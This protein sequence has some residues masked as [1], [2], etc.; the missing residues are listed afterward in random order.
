MV[1]KQWFDYERSTFKYI[2]EVKE[3]GSV[4]FKYSNDFDTNGILYWIGTNARTSKEWKNPNSIKSVVVSSS[5]G[6]NLPYG[7]LD[8]VLSRGKAAKNVHT[9]DDRNGWL[10]I[11][12]ALWIIPTHYTVRHSRGFGRSALRNWLFQV[13]KDSKGWVTL[14]TH[15]DD[16]SLSEPGSTATWEIECPGDEKQV[17]GVRRSTGLGRRF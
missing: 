4:Q 2:R 17:F 16:N 11:D 9:S 1:A 5:D 15:V 8:D 6:R 13:S 10:S 3:S 7:S 12:F 14:R